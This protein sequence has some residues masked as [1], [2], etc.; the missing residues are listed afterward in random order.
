MTAGL[1]WRTLSK[2]KC[3]DCGKPYED[4]G[5]DLTLPDEQWL[6]IH[7]EGFNGLL[8]ANCVVWRASKLPTAIV[9]RATIEF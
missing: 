6:L 4:F 8:C 1:L 5:L 3:L 9:V 7:P 2:A